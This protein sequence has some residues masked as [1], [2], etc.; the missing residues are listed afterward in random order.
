MFADS[1]KS[2]TF[3]SLLKTSTSVKE[4]WRDGRVVDCGGLEN[5]C[6]ARYRGFESL[7]LR[8]KKADKILKFIWWI[9]SAFFCKEARGSEGMDLS[10]PLSPLEKWMCRNT[11]PLLFYVYLWDD[12]E[13]FISLLRG[14]LMKTDQFLNLLPSLLVLPEKR[15]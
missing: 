2:R 5:R 1:E 6:T 13:W 8:K 11:C 3:A 15:M 14:D 9:L 10:I 4:F 7:S 12:W